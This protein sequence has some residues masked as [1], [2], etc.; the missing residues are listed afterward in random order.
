MAPAASAMIS[1]LPEITPSAVAEIL[2]LSVVIYYL[3]QIVRGTRAVQVLV[4]VLIL[5][6]VYYV[7]EWTHLT[8]IVWLLEKGFPFLVFALIVLF[9]S[10]IRWALA[11][12][13]K[14]PFTSRLSSIGARNVSE[15]IVMAASAFSTERTGALIVIERNTGLRT[16]TESGIPLDARLSYDLLKAI[17]QRNSPLHDGAAIVRKDKIVSAACFLPLSVNPGIGTQYG[18]RHRAA[19]GITEET[20]AVA[21]V[22]S[23]E[24]GAISIV[25]GGA[26]ERDLTPE[27]LAK[28]LSEILH[29]PLSAAA[30][31]QPPRFLQAET[32]GKSKS[33]RSGGVKA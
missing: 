11:K 5:V 1:T 21:V 27:D 16:Y 33:S 25:I 24:T 30:F 13:G 10:E 2:F 18:T 14:N 15:D 9:Q 26:I 6:A 29:H 31:A 20:D 12:I 8:T 7:A 23:E 4:G 19:I 17:F 3:L 28:R 32:A 22:V